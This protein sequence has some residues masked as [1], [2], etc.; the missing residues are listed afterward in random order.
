MWKRKQVIRKEFSHLKKFKNKLARRDMR[1]KETG[2]K[3]NNFKVKS[4]KNSFFKQK[5]RLRVGNR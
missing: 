3:R 2:N 1:D 5:L 4:H